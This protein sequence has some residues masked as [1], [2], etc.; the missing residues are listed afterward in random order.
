MTN[1]NA[2][3]NF[4]ERTKTCNIFPVNLI[5]PQNGKQVKSTHRRI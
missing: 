1:A 3:K 2:N 4:Y 5:H